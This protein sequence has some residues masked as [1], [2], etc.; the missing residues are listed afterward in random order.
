MWIPYKVKPK[1]TISSIVKAFKI[2]SPK[3]LLANPKNAFLKKFI[4]SNSQLPARSTIMVPNPRGKYYILKSKGGT[5]ILSEREW[6]Q[7]C[8]NLNR[9]MD[10]AWQ[11]C[12]MAYEQAR[13]RHEDQI[14][15]NGQ[16]SIVSWLIASGDGPVSQ[17]KGAKTYLDRLQKTIKSRNHK[18][19]IRDMQSYENAVYSYRKALGA[20]LNRLTGEANSW[21]KNLKLIRDTSGVVFAATASVALAPASV[22]A[23]VMVG[24]SV[25]GGVAAVKSLSDEAGNVMG[26][27]D[28]DMGAASGKRVLKATLSGALSGALSNLAGELLDIKYLK[29]IAAEI[30]E[31]RFVARLLQRTPVIKQLQQMYIRIIEKEAATAS[32]QIGMEL[33]RVA[34]NYV[35]ELPASSFVDFI[36]QAGTVTPNTVA[37]SMST[38]H[39]KK[40]QE[41]AT[42]ELKRLAPKVK[43]N[44]NKSKVSA[45]VLRDIRSDPIVV[46]ILS[47]LVTRGEKKIAAQMRDDARRQ[48]IRMAKE[49]KK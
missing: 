33:G 44:V 12:F 4:K 8:A 3:D 25:E 41:R 48:L 22:A 39:R 14:K 13:I 36:M 21:A 9:I 20:W 34:A 19:F 17:K 7:H 37:K 6:K 15:I 31:S 10:D 35:K 28:K 1:D 18:S 29:P 32:K 16:F 47:E 38:T 2:K 5:R 49:E 40:L 24:A 30:S 23:S 26:T 43:G 11:Q 27:L 46:D 42:V 45:M